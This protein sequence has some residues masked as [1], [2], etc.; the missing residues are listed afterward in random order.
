MRFRGVPL[1]AGIV[2]GRAVLFDTQDETLFR[3]T[4]EEAG[5]GAEVARFHAAR[6]K[7]VDQI[8]AIR[9]SK[10]R[11]LGDEFAAIFDAHLLMA[12]DV[13]L[14]Q[15][16]EDLIVREHMNAE[17]AVKTVVDQYLAVLAGQDNQVIQERAAD[18]EDV[19][20]R[21]QKNLAGTSSAPTAANLGENVVIIAPGLSPSDAVLLDKSHARAFA[22]DKGGATSHTA[23]IARSLEIPAVVGLRNIT[24]RVKSGDLVLVDGLSGEVIL[25]PTD[26]VIAQYKR[27]RDI[28]RKEEAVLVH[29]AAEPAVT[30]DGLRVAV[31][32]NVDLPSEVAQAPSV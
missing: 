19:A 10:A 4:V 23:I 13:S 31:R 9:D 15:R 7:T 32:A 18:L 8:R 27:K 16:T 6:E 17:W 29:R 28:W 22:T 30:A 20:R 5:V 1:S 21:I 12:E 24:K 26:A 11:E 3:V 25:R 14:I 2:W